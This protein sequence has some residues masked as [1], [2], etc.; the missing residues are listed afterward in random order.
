MAYD[1]SII[2]DTQLDTSPLAS[3]LATLGTT[4]DNSISK[5]GT[6]A[7]TSLYNTITT[8]ANTSKTESIK[9]IQAMNGEFEKSTTQIASN[10]AAFISDIIGVIVDFAKYNFGL[11]GDEASR[12]ESKIL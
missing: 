8:A 4:L 6:T 3:G 7:S 2:I 10:Q 11:I 5:I 1:G 12:L 9:T